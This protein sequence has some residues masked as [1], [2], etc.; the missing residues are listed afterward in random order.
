MTSRFGKKRNNLDLLLVV[1]R[2]KSPVRAARSRFGIAI[3]EILRIRATI[4]FAGSETISVGGRQSGEHFRSLWF[5]RSAP[6]YALVPR[7]ASSNCAITLGLQNCWWWSSSY[8]FGEQRMGRREDY[9]MKRSTQEV[10][11]S[12]YNGTRNR[13]RTLSVN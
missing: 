9:E 12:A 1:E 7:R 8:V 13:F 6:E 11:M 4:F 10:R 5:W 2:R 3:K